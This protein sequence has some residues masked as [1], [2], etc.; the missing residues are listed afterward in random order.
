MR[1]SKRRSWGPGWIVRRGAILALALLPLLQCTP[2]KETGIRL[3]IRTE[4]IVAPENFDVIQVLITSEY[5]NE[6]D[7]SYDLLSEALA[8]YRDPLNDNKVSFP[9]DLPIN[10]PFLWVWLPK[11][12]GISW[13]LMSKGATGTCRAYGSAETHQWTVVEGQQYAFFAEP[14]LAIPTSHWVEHIHNGLTRVIGE[15]TN[16]WASDPSQPMPQ[17][18]ELSFDEPTDINTVHLIF[19]TDMNTTTHRASLV[20]NCVKDYDL[21]C[22]DGRGWRTILSERDNFQRRRVHI[23][24]TIRTSRLRLTVRATHGDP[25]ARI[26]EIRA[27]EE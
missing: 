12:H 16:Q 5:F 18:V 21:A 23:F 7:R 27:Y 6:F 3:V 22:P 9:L 24:D 8:V 26:F 13:R 20:P 19:D 10:A 2:E 15:D 14:P 4:T 1:L 17:W 25:S 11:T